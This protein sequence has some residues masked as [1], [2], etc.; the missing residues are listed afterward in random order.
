ML[1]FQVTFVAS[2]FKNQIKMK[3]SIFTL[4]LLISI[5]FQTL[6]A[7]SKEKMLVM[8]VDLIG[9]NYNNER[10]L[11]YL[12]GVTRLY[13]EKSL[14]YVLVDRYEMQMAHL[15]ADSIK[16]I[17]KTNQCLVGYGKKMK[18]EK[19]LFGYLEN[20]GDKMVVS[21]QLFDVKTEMVEKNLVKE[22]LNISAESGR[23]IEITLNEM[24][25]IPNQQEIVT[26]LTKKDDFENTINS[27]YKVRLRA[28]GPRMG[29]THFTGE[30]GAILKDKVS[31]GGYNVLPTLFQFGY[32]FEKQYLNEGNFQAL[33]EFIPMVT[34]FDQGLFIPSFTLM[35]G[36]RS[37]KSGW[38]IAFGPTF[39]VANKAYGYYKD[40]VWTIA[41]GETPADAVI[42]ERMDKRGVTKLNTS[43]VIAAGKTIKSGKLNLPINIY[44]VPSRTGVRY[45][46]SFG[47][48]SKNRYH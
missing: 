36:L 27:P 8:P 37:N 38:E 10:G 5:S 15:S 2:N 9:L 31:N 46:I 24:F 6:N 17:C 26:K 18:A 47:F 41:D 35:N 42:E 28:D 1:W 19:V 14:S 32:Q 3:T 21:F 7:Q 4:A 43:F 45:G 20:L 34:G 48:N 40:G 22:F 12:S 39:S 16:R 44:V 33:A 30:N 23:M 25:G 11:S 29:F 13:A